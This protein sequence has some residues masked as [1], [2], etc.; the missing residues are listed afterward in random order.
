MAFAS[1]AGVRPGLAERLALVL[2]GGYDVESLPRLVGACLEGLS[3]EA[4]SG[5]M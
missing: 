4:H 2:E 3:G 1:L 5:A